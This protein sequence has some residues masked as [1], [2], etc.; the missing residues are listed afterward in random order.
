MA[1]DVKRWETPIISPALTELF[2]VAL[3]GY[4]GGIIFRDWVVGHVRDIIG[5]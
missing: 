1:P 5:T 4:C 3:A 2:G